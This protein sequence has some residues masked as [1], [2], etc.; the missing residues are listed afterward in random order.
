MREGYYKLHRQIQLDIKKMTNKNN[1]VEEIDRQRRAVVEACKGMNTKEAKLV[2]SLA[3]GYRP[4]RRNQPTE[5]VR[6]YVL[7]PDGDDE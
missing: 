2:K 5:V 1:G 7:G 4:D 6:T 3:L